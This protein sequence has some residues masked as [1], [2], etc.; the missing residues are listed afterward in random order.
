MPSQQ[1]RNQ[2]RGS[3]DVEA[4]REGAAGYAVEGGCVP[5]Y[6]RLV[7]GQVRGDGAVSALGGED[8]VGVG[9]FRGLG[10]GVG[11]CGGGLEG[12]VSGD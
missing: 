6:L 7:D 4:T 10:L 3:E 9:G 8:G 5:G 11:F 12:D 1:R 2:V